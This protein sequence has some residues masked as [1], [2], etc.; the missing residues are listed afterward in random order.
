MSVGERTSDWGETTYRWG[1]ETLLV[2]ESS[3]WEKRRGGGNW[4]RHAVGGNDTNWWGNTSQWEKRLTI[5]MNC[6][7]TL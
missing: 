5:L 4:K 1:K 3:R 7:L 6:V 2:G